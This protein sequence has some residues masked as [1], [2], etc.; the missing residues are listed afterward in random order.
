[1]WKNPNDAEAFP[2]TSMNPNPMEHELVM[3]AQRMVN[4]LLESMP[5]YVLA[6][7]CGIN[8]LTISR[9]A[10]GDSKLISNKAYDAIASYYA[11]VSPAPLPES[12]SADVL[13]EEQKDDVAAEAADAPAPA[14]VP[15][16]AG[17]PRSTSGTRAPAIRT[18][19]PPDTVTSASDIISVNAMRAEIERLENRIVVFR[20]MLELAKQL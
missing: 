5:P 2:N 10:K 6:T 12:Q 13:R 15:R 20:K 1:M 3:Q 17:R 16:R 18:P 14:L 7:A 11:R 8:Y 9:I 4:E 19:V